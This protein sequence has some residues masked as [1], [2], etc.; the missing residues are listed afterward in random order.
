MYSLIKV[1]SCLFYRGKKN[2]KNY[3]HSINFLSKKKKIFNK[4]FNLCRSYFKCHSPNPV[5]LNLNMPCESR[6]SLSTFYY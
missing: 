5:I 2:S 4:K 1:L 3:M 6:I